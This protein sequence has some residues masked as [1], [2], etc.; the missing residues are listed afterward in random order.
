M[1]RRK[2]AEFKEETV[3]VTGPRKTYAKRIVIEIEADGT[4][5]AS[6]VIEREMPVGNKITSEY[7]TTVRLAMNNANEYP[8]LDVDTGLPTGNTAT[9]RKLEQILFSKYMASPTQEML[10]GETN[11]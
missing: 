3:T 4:T 7:L 10:K 5:T 9:D 8:M 6:Y 1:V 2:F 11:G